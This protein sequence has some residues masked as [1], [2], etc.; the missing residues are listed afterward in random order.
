MT[1]DDPMDG[2]LIENMTLENGL[3]LEIHDRSRRVTG[4]RWL[5]SFE[6]RID[7]PVVS[8]YVEDPGLEGLSFDIIRK[9]VGAKV[10]YRYEKSRNFISEKEKDHIFN[11]LKERFIETTLP[12]F[13]GAS[14]PGKVILSK[15]Q[16]SQRASKPLLRP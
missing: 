5:V 8:E 7:I 6:A 3:T 10:T 2:K 4:D 9:A 1:N 12:Y 14:F 16:E 15:Y 13:S 11:G